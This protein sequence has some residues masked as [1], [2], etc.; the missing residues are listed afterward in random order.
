MSGGLF[1]ES[2]QEE[3]FK[4]FKVFHMANPH[5]FVLF[6]RFAFQLINAGRENY[7]TMDVIGRVR[8]E[9]AIKTTGEI[10]KINNNYAPYYARLFHVANPKHDGFFRTRRLNSSDRGATG[11]TV[12]IDGPPGDEGWLNTELGKLL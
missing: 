11:V 3:V 8:W 5:V 7:G 10:V 2:R 1:G 9:S 6:A 12:L 4:Q